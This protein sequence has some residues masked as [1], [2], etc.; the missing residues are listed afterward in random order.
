MNI[1]DLL[2]VEETSGF[3]SNPSA[4][5]SGEISSRMQ[6]HTSYGG[7]FSLFRVESKGKFRV[8]KCLK[9]EYRGDALYEGLLRKEY[10]IGS[11]LEHPNICR[12]YSFTKDSELGNWIEM[13]WVHGRTL[14]QA[15]KDGGLSRADGDRIIGELCEALSCLHS[16]QILH[17]D[18]TPSNVMLTASGNNVKLI[19]FGFSD[20]DE[21]SMLKTPAGTRSFTAPE[22]LNGQGADIRSEIWSLG[23][24]IGLI[25]GGRR[26]RTVVRRCC[27]ENPSARYASVA[28]V[29][30]ALQKRSVWM[31]WAILFV[32]FLGLVLLLQRRKE[33]PQTG[34][35]PVQ[36]DT[37]IV[38]Q[39]VPAPVPSS[40]ALPQKP[41]APRPE[42]I[43][44]R[45]SPVDSGM[46]DEIFHQAT[47]LFN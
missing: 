40:P 45:P 42:K 7:A 13:E 46:V 1:R 14:E 5:E 17:R 44:P 11:S 21:F 25:T 37:V 6:I 38:L 35:V 39:E 43:A 26:H 8:L 20:S 28:E 32:L 29:Q 19:D 9:E 16:R 41:S 15:L 36:R 2:N 33:V 24:L 31:I 22:V 30:K 18:L 12:Y 23:M 47:E 34:P 10:E 3:F 4:P 27:A